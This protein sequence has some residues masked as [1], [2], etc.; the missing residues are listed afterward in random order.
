MLCLYL[1]LT[2]NNTRNMVTIRNPHK[3]TTLLRAENIQFLCILCYF[4][5]CDSY[6]IATIPD[7]HKK[8]GD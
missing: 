8:N 2:V 3:L 1:E 4:I 5:A 7:K 6:I